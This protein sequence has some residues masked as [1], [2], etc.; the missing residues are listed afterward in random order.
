M[1]ASKAIIR[2]R[3]RTLRFGLLLDFFEFPGE[4]G[5]KRF[6]I[7]RAVV[8]LP[9]HI[10]RRR[11]LDAGRFPLSQLFLHLR[12]KFVRIQVSFEP[13]RVQADL[14]RP[15]ENML[16]GEI[17]KMRVHNIVH[18]PELALRVGG[19][20]SFGGQ[21]GLGMIAQRKLLEHQLYVFREFLQDCVDLADGLRAERS[22]IVGELNYRESRIQRTFEG[23]ACYRNRNGR[24]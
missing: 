13:V 17:A 6:R 23:S 5:R 14:F 18:F 15:P 7:E 16:A 10:E 11:A 2:L 3:S 20:R 19:K 12:L 24:L 9:V 4:H 21:R 1:S 22:L 8:F